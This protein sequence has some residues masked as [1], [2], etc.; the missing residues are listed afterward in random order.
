MSADQRKGQLPAD[1]EY[2]YAA[3]PLTPAIAAELIQE[4]FAGHIEVR[5]RIVDSV[6]DIHRERGGLEPR[7]VDHARMVKKALCSLER[8]RLATNPS[9]AQWKIAAANGQA[10]PR[11]R[12]ED[13]VLPPPPVRPPPA[14]VV[15]GEGEESVYLYYFESYRRL[16]LLDG[17]AH[18]Q[19]K[20]GRS[21]KDPYIRVVS[22]VST[23]LPEHPKIARLFRTSDGLALEAAIHAI[24]SV[25]GR[26]VKDSP[27]SEWFLTSPEEVDEIFRFIIKDEKMP[28]QEVRQS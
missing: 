10:A 25:R 8:L 20:I 13:V 26:E 22:Q 19:C 14:E 24:L 12:E 9:Y 3:Q 23:A 1:S 4:L 28:N 16:A 27:G 2:K 21:E 5:Q 17:K 11:E 15:S 18:F 7:A 6:L